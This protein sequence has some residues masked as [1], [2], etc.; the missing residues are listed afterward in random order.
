MSL[1]FQASSSMERKSHPP[2][3][4]RLSGLHFCLSISQRIDLWW[5]TRKAT[6]L[7]K[8]APTSTSWKFINVKCELSMATTVKCWICHG[9]L[10]SLLSE[11]GYNAISLHLYVYYACPT[12]INF[13]S[14]SFSRKPLHV[15]AKTRFAPCPI[16]AN[17]FR[18][19]TAPIPE[20]WHPSIQK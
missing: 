12:K 2:K 7:V 5:N 15:D 4:W 1:T 6:L 20:L 11:R 9:N 13:C 17:F 16:L 3:L 19:W 10:L 8:I 18:C 14:S